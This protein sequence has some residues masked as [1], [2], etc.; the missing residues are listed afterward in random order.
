LPNQFALYC[1]AT[2]NQELALGAIGKALSYSQDHVPSV[3]HLARYFL[4]FPASTPAP[5]QSAPSDPNQPNPRNKGPPAPVLRVQPEYAESLLTL[6]TQT[7]G[8][9]VPEAWFLLARAYELSSATGSDAAA[10]NASTASREAGK[11][12]SR[13]DMARRCLLYALELEETKTIRPIKVTLPRCL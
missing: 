4:T 6:L 11:G 9:D 3:V 12:L 2:G 1:L 7:N 13:L 10:Q 5:P 8:W